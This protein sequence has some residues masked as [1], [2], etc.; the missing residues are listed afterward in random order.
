MRK[1]KRTILIA[2]L[3]CVVTVPV[4]SAQTARTRPKLN[5]PTVQQLRDSEAE[6]QAKVTA[7]QSKEHVIHFPKDRTLGTVSVQDA[8]KPRQ[9]LAF[10]HWSCKTDGQWECLGPARGDILVPAGKRVKLTV[11][12][13]GWR[14]LSPLLNLEPDDIYELAFAPVADKRTG[15]RNECLSYVKHLTGLNTLNLSWTNLSGRGMKHVAGLSSLQRLYLPDRITDSGLVHVAKLTS[16]KGLYFWDNGVTNRGLENLVNLKLLEELTLGYQIHNRRF[17]TRAVGDDGLGYLAQLPNLRYLL[18][19][20]DRFSN[21]GLAH[22][23]N[24][25][26]LR[27][28][29]L[30]NL[31]QISDEGAAHLAGLGRLESLSAYDSC[32]TDKGMAALAKLRFLK[33]LNLGKRGDNKTKI[34]DRGLAYLENFPRMEHLHLPTEGITDKGIAGVSRLANLKY[35]WVCTGNANTL[36]DESLDHLSSLANLEDLKIAGAGFTDKGMA[37]LGEMHGLNRLTIF[38]APSVTNAGMAQLATIR[39]LESLHLANMDI[40]IQGLS[41]LNRLPLKELEVTS[42]RQDNT[43]LDISGL[44][45]LEKLTLSPN[46]RRSG[47]R[48]VRDSFSDKDIACLA[49]LKHLKNISGF[50]TL[51]DKGM[52]YLADLSKLER[53]HFVNCNITDRGL[54]YLADK[55]KLEYLS[56][57]GSFTEQGL[58]YLDGLTV[59]HTLRIKSTT[60][61][62]TRAVQQLKKRLP[63]LHTLVVTP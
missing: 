63:N 32:I 54:T 20:G 29:T 14:D 47:N 52:S 53:V 28:L 60:P 1:A 23:K 24:V 55:K 30:F 34:T 12:P 31:W 17:R 39:N 7:P 4:C 19:F 46:A 13:H 40:T 37:S 22:L 59:L 48:I 8:D 61:L 49:G 21:A 25:P 9:M 27:Y 43:I 35:L 6:Q 42:L 57:E 38:A 15:P 33:A 50:S 5:H 36:T 58:R 44:G 11:S 18:L 62:D 2:M 56:I 45:N 41:S 3:I 26:S 51:T 16:L 10:F